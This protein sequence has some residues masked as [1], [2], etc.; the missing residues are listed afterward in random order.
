M[1]LR[2]A[3]NYDRVKAS[4]DTAPAVGGPSLTQQS[5]K[6]DADINVIVKR[7]GVTGVLPQNVRTPLNIDF[8]GIFDY[9]TALDTMRAADAAFMQMPADVRTRFGNDA[10]LF[11]DFCSDP[12][13]LEECRKLGLALPIPEVVESPPMR[14][15]VVKPKEE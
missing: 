14:V 13:N 7:F 10:G 12:A 5:G 2:S 9:R 11:V 4:K 15:E 1:I 8:D 6:D 3:N